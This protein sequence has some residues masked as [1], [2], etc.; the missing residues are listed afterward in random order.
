MTAQANHSA[1]LGND[2]ASVC[3]EEGGGGG[4]VWG[5][6]GGVS[7][8]RGFQVDKAILAGRKHIC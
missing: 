3:V 5:G 8:N 7:A 6:G 4:V 2:S 1:K